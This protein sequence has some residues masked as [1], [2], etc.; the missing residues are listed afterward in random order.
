MIGDTAEPTGGVP[1]LSDAEI[2]QLYQKYIRR[3]PDDVEFASER[4]NALRYSAAGIERQIANRASNVPSIGIRG[5]EGLAPLTI[6]APVLVP[7]NH[8]GNVLTMGPAAIVPGLSYSGP[9]GLKPGTYGQFLPGASSGYLGPAG[10][11]LP[12]GLDA[13]TLLVIAAMA[14]AAYYFLVKR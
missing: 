3:P 8:L 2:V 14:G 11:S 4:Q 6:P 13:T 12:F 5:D 7:D 10:A 9:T 1:S